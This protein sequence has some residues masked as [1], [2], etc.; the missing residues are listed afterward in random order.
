MAAAERRALQVDGGPEQHVGALGPR[1]RGEGR[2]D[3]L[4]ELDVPRRA[5]GAPSTGSDTDGGPPAN[6]SPRAPLGPSVTLSAGTSPDASTFHQ[7][8]PASGTTSSS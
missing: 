7:S 3:P 6:R 1:L 8:A 5:E 4:D 2:A